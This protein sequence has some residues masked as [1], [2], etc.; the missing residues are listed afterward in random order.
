VQA[1]TLK[2]RDL[3]YRLGTSDRANVHVVAKAVPN[4]LLQMALRPTCGAGSFADCFMS[5]GTFVGPRT[6]ERTFYDLAPGTYYLVLEDWG[7]REPDFALDVDVAPATPAPHGDSCA[8]P[9]ALTLG[10]PYAGSL[11]GLQ[12]DVYACGRRELDAVHRFT[13]T[14]ASDVA[15]EAA[16]SGASGATVRVGLLSVCEGGTSSDLAQCQES[17]TGPAAIRVAGLAAG[18][19]YVVVSSESGAYDLSVDATAALR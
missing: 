18:T 10:V 12:E 15:I 6:L 5:N 8:D 2:D 9:I 13:L 17:G 7:N 1:C 16:A 11:A 4:Y 19:Y 14:Q 3:V